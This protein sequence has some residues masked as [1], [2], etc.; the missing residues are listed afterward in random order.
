MDG[1]H[2]FEEF[3]DEAQRESAGNVIAVNM[4]DG[5]F[6][7]EGGICYRAVCPADDHRGPNSPVT[8]ALFNVEYLGARCKQVDERRARDVHPALF[9]YLERL[10]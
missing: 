3:R 2:F 5:S 1:Y 6:V 9:E 4:A 10:A 8:M 7:Q